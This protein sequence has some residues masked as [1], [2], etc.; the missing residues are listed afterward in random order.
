MKAKK[1]NISTPKKKVKTKRESQ[2]KVAPT[3]KV[4]WPIFIDEIY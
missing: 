3:S 4:V 1:I 2:T